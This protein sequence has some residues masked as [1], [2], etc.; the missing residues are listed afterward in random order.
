MVAPVN[1]YGVDTMALNAPPPRKA[2]VK[3]LKVATIKNHHTG[4]LGRAKVLKPEE[5][6]QAVTYAKDNMPYGARDALLIMFSRYCGMRAKEIAHVHVEDF[7]D[8]R[9][10]IGDEL[11]ISKRGAKYGKERTVLIPAILV[12]EIKAYL[13]LTKIDSGP[14]FW[15]Q[16]GH[17][18]TSNAVQKQIK[19]AYE[20]CG[21]DKTAR[22]HSGRRFAITTLSRKINSVG[23]SIEDVRIFAGHSKLDTTKAYIDQ[24]PHAAQMRDLLL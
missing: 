19:V 6:D 8:A 3:T 1:K 13:E 7:T 5:F 4:P 14:I 18:M 21:F 20:G 23:G 11:Y 12:N 24:S 15:T 16:R 17:P 2:A 10:N 22:S 9:G